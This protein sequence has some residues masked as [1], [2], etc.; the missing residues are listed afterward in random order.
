MK[1]PKWLV[2][3]FHLISYHLDAK[4]FWI[5]TKSTVWLCS[6][7]AILEHQRKR[8]GERKLFANSLGRG[9][10]CDQP[11]G[12]NK[13]PE[14]LCLQVPKLTYWLTSACLSSLL[15]LLLQAGNLPTRWL[16]SWAR[17]H[18]LLRRLVPEP[19]V[20]PYITLSFLKISSL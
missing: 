11:Y 19:Y 7:P 6:Y 14:R 20:V 10:R 3:T 17:R 8:H 18:L 16:L 2:T 12:Y 5:S 4:S 1:P 13:I 15:P 9:C